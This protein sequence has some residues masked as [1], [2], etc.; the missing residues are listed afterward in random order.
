MSNTNRSELEKAV[1]A[2]FSQGFRLGQ[3]AVPPLHRPTVP[4]QPQPADIAGSLS[5]ARR[6]AE[7]VVIV[8]ALNDTNWNVTRAAARIG[9][10]RTNLHKKMRAL[11]ISRSAARS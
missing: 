5:A 11:G 9:I 10:E 3:D 2:A 1:I 6:E 7:R 4:I 8:T